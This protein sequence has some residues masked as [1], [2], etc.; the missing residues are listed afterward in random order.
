MERR[1]FLGAVTAASLG[2]ALDGSLT[3]LAR[4][5]NAEQAAANSQAS[6]KSGFPPNA[7]VIL[8]HERGPTARVGGTSFC[9]WK[10]AGF[11][12]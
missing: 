8:A 4:A 11:R 5:Q 10:S 9:L 7:A 12:Y 3:K 1:R 6:R 2:I